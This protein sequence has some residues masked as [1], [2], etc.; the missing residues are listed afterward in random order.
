MSTKLRYFQYRL[1]NRYIVIN[2]RREK[3]ADISPL[4]THCKTQAETTYHL[5]WQCNIAQ[6]LWKAMSQWIKYFYQIDI[7]L[8]APEIF[9]LTFKGDYSDLINTM[10]LVMNQYIYAARC[11]KQIPSYNACML[12]VYDLMKMEKIVANRQDMYTAFHNKG[13]KLLQI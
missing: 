9:L 10:I 3:Y 5:F 4:C 13:W 8:T 11:L 12:T 7:Q 2:I 1:V 6:K